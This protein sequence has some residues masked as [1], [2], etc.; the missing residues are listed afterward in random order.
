MSI[1][2]QLAA[3]YSTA[4]SQL[5]HR[6]ERRIL[7]LDA[8]VSFGA[9]GGRHDT[10]AYFVASANATPFRDQLRLSA[11]SLVDSKLACRPL[12]LTRGKL[13]YDY[14]ALDIATAKRLLRGLSVADLKTIA[15]QAMLADRNFT[16]ANAAWAEVAA[17]KGTFSMSLL[18]DMVGMGAHAG[19]IAKVGEILHKK[20]NIL[21]AATFFNRA[22]ELCEQT[23][24][25]QKELLALDWAIPEVPKYEYIRAALER[26][27]AVVT[28]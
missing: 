28:P 4:L 9:K 23:K 12:A 14:A 21:D 1:Q 13:R 19:Q 3:R 18:E 20:G 10:A 24:V 2:S 16:V 11:K 7:L 15:R 5:A 8:V 6:W 25:A 17:R 22:V 27:M 26:L